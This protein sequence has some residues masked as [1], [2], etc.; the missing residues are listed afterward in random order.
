MPELATIASQLGAECDPDDALVDILEALR[1]QHPVPLLVSRDDEILGSVGLEV[2][3][4]AHSR[5]AETRVREVMRPAPRL[6][7][8]ERVEKGAAAVRRGD[9]DAIV[10]E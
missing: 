4:G 8:G 10:V 5:L 9:S 6:D 1:A 3:L 7:L 2:I